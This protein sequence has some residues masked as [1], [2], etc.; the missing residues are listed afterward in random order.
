MAG[1]TKSNY[2][3]N[4]II[5]TVKESTGD[6]LFHRCPFQGRVA[7]MNLTMKNDK[8]FSI[9]PRGQYRLR[10]NLSDGNNK[11]MFQ[12]AFEIDLTE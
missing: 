5:N 12:V 11:E 6:Q 3:I 9:Y 8:L 4:F 1:S 2:M 7:M 10:V